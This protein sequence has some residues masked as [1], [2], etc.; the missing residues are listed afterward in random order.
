MK[1]KCYN[2]KEIAKFCGVEVAA[3]RYRIRKLDLKYDFKTKNETYY[4]EVK[5]IEIFNFSKRKNIEL[6]TPV[7]IHSETL[8]IPSKLNF[9]TLEQL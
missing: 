2:T 5:R 6:F 8:I 3:V 7:Y 1:N 4:S 9:L